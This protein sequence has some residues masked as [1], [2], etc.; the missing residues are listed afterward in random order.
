MSVLRRPGLY[1][2][3]EF[4]GPAGHIANSVTKTWGGGETYSYS[5][6]MTGNKGALWCAR[7]WA[8]YTPSG[9]FNDSGNIC[10]GG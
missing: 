4:F 10:V 5:R 1:G 8:Y 3:F 7:F 9:W 6:F 2:H